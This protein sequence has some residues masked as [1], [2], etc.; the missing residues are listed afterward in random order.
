VRTTEL[1]PGTH[2]VQGAGGNMLACAGRQGLMLVDTDYLEMSGKLVAALDSIGAGP[3]RL[4]VNTHWHFD[5]VGGNE[6]LARGG[7]TII[8]HPHLRERMEKG[9][10]IAVIDETIAP[11]PAGALPRLTFTDSL[12]LHL[13]GETIEIRH[14]R[15]AHTD[16]DAVVRFRRADVIHAGDLWFH[17][18]YPFVDVSSGGDIDGLIAAIDVVIA[19]AGDSTRIVPGHGPVGTKVDL[20]AHRAMLQEFRDIVAREIAA[21]KDLATI[22][23]EKPTARLDEVWGKRIFP[24]E[25]FTEMVYR[26]LKRD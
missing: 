11:A 15:R 10:T 14:P 24:P 12:T 8:A 5:H 18:G 7:A 19:D 25:A 23:A 20:A 1:A 6:A 2:L 21:G 13:N 3:C 9:Q 22:V 4:V 26:S 16:G 17:G